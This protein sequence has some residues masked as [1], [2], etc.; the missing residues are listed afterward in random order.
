MRLKNFS[1]IAV[2][3][4]LF[5]FSFFLF[6]TQEYTQ[7]YSHVFAETEESPK[8]AGDESLEEQGPTQEEIDAI[9][10]DDGYIVNLGSEITDPNLYGELLKIIKNDS[11]EKYGLAYSGDSVYSTMFKD[12]TEI[13]IQN[14]NISSL[15]GLEHL[16]LTNLEKLNLANNSITT[17]SKN[18]FT[19]TTHKLTYVN[20]ANN[21]IS[22]CDLTTLTRLSYVNLSSNQLTSIDLSNIVTSSLNINLA[23]NYF[24]SINNIKIPTR[25]ESIRLNIISNDIID[26]TEDHFNLSKLTMNVGVQGIKGK[27]NIDKTITTSNQITFYKTNIEDCSIEIYKMEEL[28]DVLVETIKDGDITENSI[29]RKFGVGKYYYVYKING[30]DVYNKLDYE[31]AYFTSE[32]FNVIPSDPTYVFEYKGQQYDTLNKVTGTVKVLLATEDD[33]TIYYSINGGGWVKGNEVVCSDG[34]NYTIRIKSVVGDIESNQVTVLVKTSLNAI[35]PDALML[36]LILMFAIVLFVVVVP[37]VGKK[38]FRK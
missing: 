5:L 2:L 4:I 26:L 6:N 35:I 19:Y 21:K 31:K 28:N 10:E 23:N 1:K 33:A 24:T 13:N 34:G 29:T 7:K 15:S 16:V 14:K 8:G 37:L 11:K 9:Y 36:V 18:I 38:F 30:E 22:N 32:K 20:F 3:G 25:V 27:V 17:I 12:I